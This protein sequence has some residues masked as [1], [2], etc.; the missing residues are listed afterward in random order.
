MNSNKQHSE[1]RFAVYRNNPKIPQSYSEIFK[2]RS[3]KL[4][5]AQELSSEYRLSKQGSKQI[6]L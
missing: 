3:L 2:E 5:S 1:W 4:I 6:M